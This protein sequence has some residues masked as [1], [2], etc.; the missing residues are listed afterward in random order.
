MAEAAAAAASQAK[1]ENVLV[2]AMRQLF[3][4]AENYPNLKADQNFLQLQGELTNTED[5]I[6]RARRFYN[7]NARDLN[8]RIEMFPSSVIAGWFKFAK[9]EYFEVEDAAMRVAPQVQFYVAHRRLKGLSSPF[10]ADPLAHLEHVQI[11]D[12]R[13]EP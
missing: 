6:Q 8:N 13:S 2:G 12:E 11:D 7:G 9:R 3:A 5:R 1:D 10:R 4:L